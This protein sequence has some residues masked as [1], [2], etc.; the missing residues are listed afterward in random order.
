MVNKNRGTKKFLNLLNKEYV[1]YMKALEQTV[2]IDMKEKVLTEGI[3]LSNIRSNSGYK[4][5][6]MDEE[7]LDNYLDNLSEEKQEITKALE[8]LESVINDFEAQNTIFYFKVLERI[9]DRYQ[10]KDNIRI[11]VLGFIL[12]IN[13]YNMEMTYDY[14]K[15][16]NGNKSIENL[17][18]KLSQDKQS[19]LAEFLKES[20]FMNIISEAEFIKHS[21]ELTSVWKKLS[22]HITNDGRFIIPE[23]INDFIE[24]LEGSKVPITSNQKDLILNYITN[25]IELS[26]KVLE[27]EIVKPITEKEPQK[28]VDYKSG[29]KDRKLAIQEL[30]EYLNK[31]NTPIKYIDLVELENIEDLLKKIGYTENQILILKKKILENNEKI[32]NNRYQNY[33]ELAKN[34]YLSVEEQEILLAA[35]EIITDEN[36]IKNDIYTSIKSSYDYIKNQ[37]FTFYELNADEYEE[38]NDDAELMLLYI[39]EL[40]NTIIS[41]QASDYRRVLAT[42]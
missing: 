18:L 42:I 38:Y 28:E 27:K 6:M 7:T 12:K 25:E 37:L 20:K 40:R 3:K 2:R 35:E 34:K 22:S 9:F 32:L 39:E 26:K 33:Y 24:A 30:K 5:E 1:K 4:L 15:L 31:D 8:C 13:A 16:F 19:E 10:I 11:D 21:E 36:S 41:Y 29:I 14:I 23:Q 17:F